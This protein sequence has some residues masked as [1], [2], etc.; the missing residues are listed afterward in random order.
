MRKKL[1][2]FYWLV[3]II[4][5]AGLSTSKIAMAY[6]CERAHLPRLPTLVIDGVDVHTTKKLYKSSKEV[7]IIIQLDFDILTKFGNEL[8][9]YFVLYLKKWSEALEWQLVDRQ[10]IQMVVN[11]STKLADNVF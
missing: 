9:M 11:W 4:E 6:I 10:I 7:Y 1:S 8:L 5:S 3:K 2:V